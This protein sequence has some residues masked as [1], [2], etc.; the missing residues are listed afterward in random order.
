VR[1]TE[2]K[3]L[4]DQKFRPTQH[5]SRNALGGRCAIVAAERVRWRGGKIA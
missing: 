2:G 1:L 4:L 3:D 5:V